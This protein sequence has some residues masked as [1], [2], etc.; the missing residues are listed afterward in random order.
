MFVKSE[1]CVPLIPVPV[2]FPKSLVAV[3]VACWARP[4]RGYEQ[5]Q[6]LRAE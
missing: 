6:E 4:G 3:A 1:D 2:V 5:Q